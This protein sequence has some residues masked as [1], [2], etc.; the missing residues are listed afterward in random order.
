MAS[1]KDTPRKF[2]TSTLPNLKSARTPTTQSQPLYNYSE[3]HSQLLRSKTRDV[4]HTVSPQEDYFKLLFD[5]NRKTF[6]VEDYE[7]VDEFYTDD[8]IKRRI[9]SQGFRDPEYF[10][11]RNEFTDM[12]VPD[13]TTI[14]E[15]YRLKIPAVISTM[16]NNNTLA[17]HVL[18][19]TLNNISFVEVNIFYLEIRLINCIVT[20]SESKS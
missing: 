20:T 6:K 9:L 7:G 19:G 4:L 3:H 16:E 11:T 17:T 14:R 5:E 12:Q 2:H 18:G 15:E 10:A 8:M 13:E 1:T